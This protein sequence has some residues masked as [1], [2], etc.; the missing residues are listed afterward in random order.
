MNNGWWNSLTELPLHEGIWAEKY[1]QI[2]A[3]HFDRDNREDPNFLCNPTGS[4][5]KNNIW[6]GP[7]K[8]WTFS[9]DPA[10]HEYS[11][12]GYNY[13]HHDLDR[14]FE[15]GTYELTKVASRDKELEWEPIP[16]DQFGRYE[17]D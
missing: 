8:R 7:E 16:Y 4:V 10:V 3:I 14:V 17:I 6:I 9:I 13:V 2:A 11:E 12:V 15:P 5:I 1:P